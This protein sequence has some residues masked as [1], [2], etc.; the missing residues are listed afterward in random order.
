MFLEDQIIKDFEK[1]EKPK[2]ITRNY[3][4]LDLVP[5]TIMNNDNEEDVQED[6]SNAVNEPIS[7]NDIQM[8]IL[9]KPLKN[10]QLSLS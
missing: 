6:D 1:I 7:N 3:I 8:S 10:H 4:D 9:S 5:P 2:S